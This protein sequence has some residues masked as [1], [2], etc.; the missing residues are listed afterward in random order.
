MRI[1][2]KR[3]TRLSIEEARQEA[4]LVNAEKEVRDLTDRAD[5]AIRTLEARSRRNHWRESI[6]QMIQGA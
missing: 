1:K 6:E 2:R 3:D 5:A 4:N